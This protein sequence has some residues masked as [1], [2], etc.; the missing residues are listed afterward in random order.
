MAVSS[1]KGV[2]AC[3]QSEKPWQSESTVERLQRQI[4][5]KMSVE[6]LRDKYHYLMNSESWLLNIFVCVP[7]A[8]TFFYEPASLAVN[9]E[10]G[11]SEGVGAEDPRRVELS[12]ALIGC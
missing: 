5:R 3:G 12:T 6:S 11:E 9:S 8:S 1:S 7:T 10:L 2:A 4:L